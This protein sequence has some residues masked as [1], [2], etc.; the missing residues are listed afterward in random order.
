MVWRASLHSALTNCITLYFL[1]LHILD[2]LASGTSLPPGRLPLPIANYCLESS[3]HRQT[4]QP[5][6]YICSKARPLCG[7]YSWRQCS[8]ALISP[9]PN[10]WRKPL[11]PRAGGN[12]SNRPVPNPSTPPPLPLHSFLEK[13][14]YRL[15]SLLSACPVCVLTNG[16]LPCVAQL[17]G[18]YE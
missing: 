8:S 15:S 6:G 10:N 16:G 11:C 3:F 2:A 7:F 4:N 12:G 1:I 5:T 9:E 18:N 13:P 14:Q 17:A